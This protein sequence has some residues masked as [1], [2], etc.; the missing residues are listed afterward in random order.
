MNSPQPSPPSR[1]FPIWPFIG[2]FAIVDFLTI[3]VVTYGGQPVV[4]NELL[5]G[6]FYGVILGQLGLLS[7]W[8]VFGP[9]S[10]LVRLPLT[11]MVGMFLVACFVGG[12]AAA[13]GTRDLPGEAALVLLFVPLILLSAQL[14]LW[15]LKLV[16]GGR[17]VRVD[18]KTGQMP[19]VQRQFGIGHLMAATVVVALAFGLA[20][21]GMRLIVARS[22]GS[23]GRPMEGMTLIS[24]V[25]PCVALCLLNLF[26][27]LPCLW[28]GLGAKNPRAGA[29]GLA[30]YAGLMTLLSVAIFA[31]FSP[32][33]M[34]RLLNC[35]PPMV[36]TLG[37]LYVARWCGYRYQRGGRSQRVAAAGSPFAAG[38][39]VSAAA[40]EAEGP[41][42]KSPTDRGDGV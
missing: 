41:T 39:E 6:L 12:F 7:I 20:S 18:T 24:L 17:I 2:L 34:E 40:Q 32:G 42:D 35:G 3:P 14:P 26:V 31:L 10:A 13:V 30:I 11:T 22:F 4:P 5:L 19:T 25:A 36:V 8:A 15:V 9:S 27:T 28:A 1:R 37:M 21:S 23:D 29:V 33:P 38:R 16:T